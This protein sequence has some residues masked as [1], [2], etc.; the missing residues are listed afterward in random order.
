VK[1][2]LDTNAC[3]EYLRGKRLLTLRVRQSINDCSSSTIIAAELFVWGFRAK[4]SYPP[5]KAFYKQFRSME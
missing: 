5:S 1:Y 3:S 2:L 4:S